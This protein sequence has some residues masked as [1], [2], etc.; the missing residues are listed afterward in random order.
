VLDGEVLHGWSPSGELML[1]SRSLTA[2]S[3]SFSA[4]SRALVSTAVDGVDATVD[5]I[6]A[7]LDLPGF[8]PLMLAH[9][10]GVRALNSALSDLAACGTPAGE[11]YMALQ[12]PADTGDE[13][14]LALADGLGE[15][16]RRHDVSVIGGDVTAGAAVSVTVTVGGWLD[17][18]PLLRSG[19]SPGDLLALTGPIGGS[20]GGLALLQHASLRYS[21]PA[22]LREQLEDRYLRPQP[23]L[24]EGVALRAAGATAAIDLSD[25]LVADAGH[26][27]DASGVALQFN[28]EA[29]P[30]QAGVA[31]VAMLLDLSPLAFA[32]SS[33]E[34]YELLVAVP[35][36]SVLAAELAGAVH[37][38][39]R[40]IERD[41]GPAV[42]GLPTTL[43][44][45]WDHRLP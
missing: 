12:L 43:R 4:A 38:V 19:A 18:E 31:S 39:G 33:G 3:R 24:T 10:M 37:W 13:L 34:D 8:D 23:R 1:V 16:A 45:G 42:R 35:R 9:A 27:A 21:F 25:G 36:G 6:H 7:R 2:L 17:D 22:E 14:A 28:P 29:I 26:L 15:A 41:D 40:V 44:P 11:A 5:G 20:G 32:A 30:L